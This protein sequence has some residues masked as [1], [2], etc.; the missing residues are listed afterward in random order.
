MSMSL[1]IKLNTRCLYFLKI[2]HRPEK[3]ADQHQDAANNSDED[4]GDDAP[5]LADVMREG[6]IVFFIP[7]VVLIG[8]LI[9]GF[10]PTYAAGAGIVAATGTSWL[11]KRHRMGPEEIFDALE[12]GTRNM[13]MTAVLLCAV[14]LIVNVRTRRFVN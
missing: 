8:V 4:S 12:L 7:V 14:G 6:G 2:H 9:A 10:T 13:V 1:L 5:R 11:T 3:R